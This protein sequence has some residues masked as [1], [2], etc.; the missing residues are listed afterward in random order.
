MAA[1]KPL[2]LASANDSNGA[3]VRAQ[4]TTTRWLNRADSGP[5]SIDDLPAGI[6]PLLP[7]TERLPNGVTCA[8]FRTLP[9][10]NAARNLADQAGSNWAL[11]FGHPS[12]PGMEQD[13]K[14][15]GITAASGHGSPDS[16]LLTPSGALSRPS[17]VAGAAWP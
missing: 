13:R 6:D 16:T 14:V 10:S 7:Y 12:W 17:R 15:T 5:S 11:G 4:A 1:V 9:V 8:G 3:S 2:W